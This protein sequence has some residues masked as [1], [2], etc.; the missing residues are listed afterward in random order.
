MS[1]KAGAP[2]EVS[3]AH[4]TSIWLL[5]CVGSLVLNKVAVL[6]ESFPAFVTFKGLLSCVNS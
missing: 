1:K 5:A 4:A 2:A 3:P 6:N